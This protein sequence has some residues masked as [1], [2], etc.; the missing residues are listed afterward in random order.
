MLVAGLS[1]RDFLRE[2]PRECAHFLSLCDKVIVM[3]I[4]SSVRENWPHLKKT[5]KLSKRVTPL[6]MKALEDYTEIR[7]LD[8]TSMGLEEILRNV[9]LFVE[10]RRELAERG[11]F[12]LNRDAIQ[13]F[14]IR[15]QDLFGSHG[16]QARVRSGR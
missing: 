15:E 6:A 4:I 16:R 11:C 5:E 3:A 8:N 10:I 14:E 2:A 12:F 7:K 1:G 13:F 9:H